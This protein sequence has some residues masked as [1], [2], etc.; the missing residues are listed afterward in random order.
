MPPL[1]LHPEQE[2]FV[3]L[4]RNFQPASQSR[5]T[6]A[7]TSERSTSGLGF[8]SSGCRGAFK[9]SR[10]HVHE[11]LLISIELA[12]IEGEQSSAPSGGSVYLR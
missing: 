11:L 2:H 6:E 8:A 1:M 3:T 9:A 7:E 12:R 5:S 4:I 10:A